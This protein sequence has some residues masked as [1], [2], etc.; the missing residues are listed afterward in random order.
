M[1]AGNAIEKK[2]VLVTGGSRG[3][4]KGLVTALA[5]EGYTVAFTYQSSAEAANRLEQDIAD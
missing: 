5:A 2:W 3:I 4:G 1:E